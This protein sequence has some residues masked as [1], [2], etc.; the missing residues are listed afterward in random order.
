VPQSG[1]I[2]A[3]RSLLLAQARKGRGLSGVG[4]DVGR[5]REAGFTLIEL[6]VVIAIIAILGG[7]LLPAV[8]RAKLR[9]HGTSCLNNLKQ[10]GLS[11]RMYAD[12]N[13]DSFPGSAHRTNSW[14]AALQ[15]Y[16]TTTNL[17]R[18]PKDPD[19]TRRYSYAINDFLTAHPFGA[20]HLD[21]SKM[22][23]ITDPTETFYMTESRPGIGV[24]DHYHFAEAESGGYQAEAFQSQV[25]VQRHL[26][27]ANYLFV[28]GHADMLPWLRVKGKLSEVGSYFVRPNGHPSN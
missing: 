6:L 26:G 5:H 7:L 20:S 27:A 2:S 17:Y 4:G 15:P 14:V 16:L 8:S 24:S 19:P 23:S 25:D 1:F 21:F 12:D 22:T 11:V 9:V 28:D 18:C 13:Q 10:I 3:F